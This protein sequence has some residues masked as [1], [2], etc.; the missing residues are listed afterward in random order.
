[1][2]STQRWVE[3]V[4][5][6][7]SHDVWSFTKPKGTKPM[8]THIT[9]EYHVSEWGWVFV[10]TAVFR[11]RWQIAWI[12]RRS[13]DVCESSL[14]GQATVPPTLPTV[15]PVID[16]TVTCGSCGH[17]MT[18][19]HATEQL[20]HGWDEDSASDL[21][22]WVLEQWH[23]DM[24]HAHAHIMATLHQRMA[25]VMR[26]CLDGRDPIYATYELHFRDAHAWNDCSVVNPPMV[27]VQCSE[28][29]PWE[30]E[31]LTVQLQLPRSWFSDDLQALLPP[32]L[33]AVGGL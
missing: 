10:N 15:G 5:G 7:I 22:R 23:A 17:I 14:P 33:R 28:P 31:L 27:M 32:W 11:D 3:S 12:D 29:H 9:S 6:H 25:D 13:C 21:A 2:D 16:W 8:L 20:P 4:P 19:W 24:M 26:R 1:M 30:L 18:R